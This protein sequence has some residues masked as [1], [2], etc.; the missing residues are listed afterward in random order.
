MTMMTTS[1]APRPPTHGP[2]TSP[3]APTKVTNWQ[4]P[5]LMPCYTP[6][7]VYHDPIPVDRMRTLRPESLRLLAAF[8]LGRLRKQ[9][10]PVTNVPD[11]QPIPH[12]TIVAI[13]GPSGSGKTSLIPPLLEQWEMPQ[14]LAHLPPDVDRP[15]IDRWP[16]EPTAAVRLLTRVGLTDA[17]SWP[18]LPAELSEGQRH[19]YHLANPSPP[20]PLIPAR[21]ESNFLSVPSPP[22][23][24]IP[25]RLE[26][27]FLSV[28][29]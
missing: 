18:R 25:A 15:L 6:R 28:Y 12:P 19:R 4:T 11:L 13:T 5:S 8:G 17:F 23:P 21:L 16:L 22:K 27:N 14:C 2:T 3:R 29:Q 9:R 26:S 10:Q 1:R 7:A 20:K 24:L